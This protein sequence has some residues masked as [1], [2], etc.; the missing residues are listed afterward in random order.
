[1]SNH[2]DASQHDTESQKP[3]PVLSKF[4]W[5]IDE[6]YIALIHAVVSL[7]KVLPFQLARVLNL[8]ARFTISEPYGSE[9]S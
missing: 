4:A 2:W 5:N 1:M 3:A 6:Q 8:F 7:K 9:R